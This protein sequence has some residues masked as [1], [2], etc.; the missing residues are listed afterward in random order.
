MANMNE[1]LIIN[2]KLNSIKGSEYFERTLLYVI[3]NDFQLT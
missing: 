3:I 1:F 2:L